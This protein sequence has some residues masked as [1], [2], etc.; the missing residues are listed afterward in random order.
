MTA[1][2][3]S[4][5][6]RD[7]KLFTHCTG[8]AQNCM[9]QGRGRRRLTD[10]DRAPVTRTSFGFGPGGLFF[11]FDAV[12]TLSASRL[13]CQLTPR[14]LEALRIVAVQREYSAGEEIFREGDIGDG[15]YVIKAG[16]VEICAAISDE[17]RRVFASLEPGDFFG[18]MAV[19]DYR[20]RS[21]S[22]RAAVETVLYFIPRLEI[23][24]FIER[25][26]ILAMTLLREI[27]NRQREFN[28]R[29]LTEVVAAERLS[30][31]GQFA[32]S[33][34]HDIKNPL[35]IIGLSAEL[36]AS[37]PST[38]ASGR[39]A[40]G[41]V[42][43]QVTR[44]SDLIGEVLDFSRGE[45]GDSRLVATNYGD[46]V[47]QLLEETSKEAK[48][49]KV[50]IYA[51]G[52][53]P[54]AFVN[55]NARRLA[56]VFQ[57]LFHNAM[58]FVPDNTGSI[59]VKFQESGGEVL[60]EIEDNGPGIAAEVAEH[61]FEPFATYGK[62]QGTGLGLCICKR[63]VEAHHGWIQA[64]SEAGRGA[65]FT[66]GLPICEAPMGPGFIAKDAIKAERSTL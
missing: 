6:T 36:T 34:L 63:I 62:P 18:E 5:A 9:L 64:R 4:L 24:K 66:F 21:G 31:L 53:L 19:L 13:F 55:M 33:I 16:S 59:K 17:V 41:I 12:V 35:N 65:V 11:R 38:S 48:L 25:S 30:M 10:K 2:K 8:R 27:S 3:L 46:F 58:D 29:F 49:R 7:V 60:T 44:I 42:R 23:L 26:P 43:R 61:L 39:E 47:R 54:Q 15:L 56:R 1:H 22:A 14:E 32:G 40:M 57:N 45:P 52:P 20:R 28:Q 51:V 37:D 50:R